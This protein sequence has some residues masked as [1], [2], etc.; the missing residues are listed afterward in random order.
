MVFLFIL[1]IFRGVLGTALWYVAL[2]LLSHDPLGALGADLESK[3]ALASENDALRAELAST[4]ATLADRNVLYQENLELK[5]RLDR[6]GSMHTILAG[7]ILRPPA[8]PYDTLIIDAGEAQGV[9][10]G[11]LVS[12]GGTTLIGTVDEVFD[13][14]SRVTL[15]SAPGQ[16]Y[17]AL[18]MET[19]TDASVAITVQ[20]QGNG[21]L[22]AEVPTTVAA[23]VGD[24]V[25]FPGVAGGFASVVVAVDEQSG[26]SFESLYMRLPVDPEQLRYVEVLKQ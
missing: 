3:A 10:E 8:T 4:S 2:P 17:Q 25:V 18:L 26:E 21:S 20:G 6:D 11:A 5:A 16:T 9:V 15:F 24:S 13:S 1:I 7:V 14:T 23:A 12:A 22:V 19:S